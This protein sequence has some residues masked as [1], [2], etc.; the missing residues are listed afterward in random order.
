MKRIIHKQVSTLILT[1]N[2]IYEVI[3][4][5]DSYYVILNDKGRK[6][7]FLKE[8]FNDID[9]ERNDKINNILTQYEIY[10]WN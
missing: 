4:E 2:K 5:V 8:R 6:Q 1:Q 3:E 9:T 10:P 7:V